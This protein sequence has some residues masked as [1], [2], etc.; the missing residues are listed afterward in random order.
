[1]P[2]SFLVRAK[3]VSAAQPTV[4]AEKKTPDEGESILRIYQCHWFYVARRLSCS[5]ASWAF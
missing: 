4:D 5:A 3:H 1:M 2:R